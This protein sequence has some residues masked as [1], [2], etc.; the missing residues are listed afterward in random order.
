MNFHLPQII[1]LLIF[2]LNFGMVFA[3]HGEPRTGKK[4]AWDLLVHYIIILTLLY[5]GGFFK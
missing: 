2:V 3:K 1:L 4:N 5:W